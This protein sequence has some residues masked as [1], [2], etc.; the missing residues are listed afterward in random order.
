MPF[1]LAMM[2]FA[3]ILG[4]DALL[5]SQQDCTSCH[6]EEKRAWENS[7]HRHAM[8]PADPEWVLGDFDAGDVVEGEYRARFSMSGN[9]YWVQLENEKG[10]VRAYKIAYTFGWHPLQQYLVQVEAP[11]GEGLGTLQCLPWAWDI[12]KERWFHL[13]VSENPKPGES[14]HWTGWAQNWNHMCADCHV[15]SYQK[16]F[17]PHQKKFNSTFHHDHVHCLACH[18]PHGEKKKV[19]KKLKAPLSFDRKK[20]RDEL[21]RCASCHS[22][23]EQIAGGKKPAANFQDHYNLVLPHANQYHLDGQIK[24]EVYVMGSFLQSKMHEAGVR[25]S[26]CH[27]PH[28]LKLKKTGSQVCFQCH[29]P[30]KYAVS[31]HHHHKEGSSG[32]SCLECHMPESVYMGIDRRRD[33]S[34]RVPR[35]DLSLKNS[36]PNACTGCHLDLK[37][38]TQNEHYQNWLAKGQKEE[39]ILELNKKM[40]KAY[41]LWYGT[42]KESV[43]EIVS[44]F[45]AGD[46]QGLLSLMS[47]GGLPEIWVATLLAEGWRPDRHIL[48]GL[49]ERVRP[50]IPAE[51]L[52]E[53]FI[54]LKDPVRSVRMATLREVLPLGERLTKGQREKVM[55]QVILEDVRLFLKA[56]SDQSGAHQLQAQVA[57]F[58][59]LKG[60][61]VQ[62]LKLAI[63]IQ[64]DVTGARPALAGLVENEKEGLVLL[65]EEIDLLRVQIKT[66]PEEPSL[67]YSLGLLY[68]R[69]GY[70][71]LCLMT[72]KK[73]LAL[74][75]RDYNAGAFVI[76]LLQKKSRQDEAKKV[77][78]KLLE[79]HPKD[80]WLRSLIRHP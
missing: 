56:N 80:P 36:T 68:Y 75:P 40:S 74:S 25:C 34:F 41:S 38:E 53:L 5:G 60:L 7:H 26:H 76:Q 18:E 20:Q 17:D 48:K 37:K 69:V 43:Y 35:P 66:V 27:D 3:I 12:E 65:K 73:V 57:I 11:L 21:N 46:D 55:S 14:I 54:R 29:E 62:H 24:G 23:R 59:G 45:R 31:S 42:P 19:E 30:N 79:F 77:A 70:E 72:M 61:A 8:H 64:A 63:A 78:F 4:E 9:S 28:S 49:G 52:G 39:S 16:N 2:M 15:T 44:R 67:H 6:L 58:R 13:F 22:F 10:K 32:S 51:S 1:V 71:D 47:R 33:H 50:Q